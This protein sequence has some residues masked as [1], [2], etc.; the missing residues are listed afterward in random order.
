M[1]LSVVIPS[2]NKPNYLVQ[3]IET[4]RDQT[5]T[6]WELI[7]VDDGSDKDNKEQVSSYVSQDNRISF[8]ERNRPPKNG[9]TCRNIGM[10]LARGKYI[11]IFD[12]DDLVAKEC[13]A[14]R[15]AYMEEHPE[16]DY[17]SFPSYSFVN[18][19]DEKRLRSFETKDERV[20]DKILSAEY[21]FTV[22]G[23]IYK[24][25]SLKDIRWDE[26]AYVYQDFDFMVQCEL[27]GL[28][29]GWA[30]ANAVPDYYYRVFNDGNSVC[31][32]V[33]SRQKVE[34]TN[35]LFNKIAEQLKIME[36]S[37]SLLKLFFRFILLHYEQM[38]LEY[39]DNY[40]ESY[41]KVIS[42]I[43]PKEYVKMQRIAR[44]RRT[45]AP[46]H[47]NLCIMYAKLYLAY[48]EAVHR[49]YVMHEFGKW[50]LNK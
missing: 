23:N 30:D 48:G 2:Y 8:I 13:F 33:V 40:I 11:I 47:L 17:A 1:I 38:L 45:H 27:K 46:S 3:M 25:D 9:D 21:P 44:W 20:L 22:W 35:Y 4:I 43:Y 37:D 10:D 49:I 16:C 14:Q 26:K 6:D 12:S 15:V 24:R 28:Q 39:N 29:H 50:I 31:A 7:I 36:N 42:R 18:G 32:K 41:F 34:S 19:T 5:F